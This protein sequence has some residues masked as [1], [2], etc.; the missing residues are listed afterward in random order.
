MKNQ[1]LSL[2]VLFALAVPGFARETASPQT[3]TATPKMVR[4]AVQGWCDA[5]LLISKTDMQG[6]DA[7]KVA[8][9]V[10][11]SAYNY[12]DGNMTLFK[13]TLTSGA[14]TFRLT[15]QGALA[16][17]VGGDKKY[18]NDTGFA[19][20]NWVKARF[21]PAGI[22]VDGDIGIFMGNVY[23]TDAKGKTTMVDKTFVFKFV[24]GKPRILVHKSA[25]PFTPPGKTS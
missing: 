24:D 14:Q 7:K 15:K 3:T 8:S 2:F 11:D 6:G 13:P 23:L 4:E 12:Q 20:K 10:L 17:F 5:L 9:Q 16:Y 25:L 22:I 19:R 21:K 1:I 18:P